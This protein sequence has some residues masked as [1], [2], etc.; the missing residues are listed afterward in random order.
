MG[1]FFGVFLGNSENT[2]RD[3]DKR[4]GGSGAEQHRTPSGALGG[5]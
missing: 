1:D 3:F 2:T 5:K 4:G